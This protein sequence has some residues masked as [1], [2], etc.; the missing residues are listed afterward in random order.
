MLN[1]EENINASKSQEPF[2]HGVIFL[3]EALGVHRVRVAVPVRVPVLVHVALA[4]GVAV[5]VAS[6]GMW[7]EMEQCISTHCSYSQSYQES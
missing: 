4:V 3:Q 1:D 2:E 6:V 7:Q 5:V